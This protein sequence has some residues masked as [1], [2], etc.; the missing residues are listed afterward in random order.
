MEILAVYTAAAGAVY[1]IYDRERGAMGPATSDP[2]FWMAL[3]TIGLLMVSLAQGFVS[4]GAMQAKL[5][6]VEARV[7]RIEQLLDQRLVSLE[8]ARLGD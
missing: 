2:N 8:H 4:R 6:Q 1:T 5:E 7:A 3:A